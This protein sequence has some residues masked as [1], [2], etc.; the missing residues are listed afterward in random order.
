MLRNVH[1][2]KRY[3]DRIRF[4]ELVVCLGS[5]AASEWYLL[6]WPFSILHVGFNL[7]SHQNYD[8]VLIEDSSND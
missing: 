5:V 8:A 1:V 7:L 4:I 2:A 3:L 6:W